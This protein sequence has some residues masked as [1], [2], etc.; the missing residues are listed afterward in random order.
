MSIA[1]SEK[2]AG[3]DDEQKKML[4]GTNE[5][6]TRD[7]K[8]ALTRHGTKQSKLHF[9]HPGNEKTAIDAAQLEVNTKHARNQNEDCATTTIAS[10]I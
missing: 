7:R 1:I 8:A 4:T 5:R 9:E 10:Q 2:K 6:S 3:N